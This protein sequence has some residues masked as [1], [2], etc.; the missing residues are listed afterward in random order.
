L[1]YLKESNAKKNYISLISS[2]SLILVRFIEMP[3]LILT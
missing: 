1:Q 3:F 2:N